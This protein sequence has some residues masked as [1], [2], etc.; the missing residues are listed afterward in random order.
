MLKSELGQVFTKEKEVKKMCSLIKNSGTILEPSAGDGSFYNVL[1]SPMTIGI[2]ID[3][4]VAPKGCLVMDFFDYKTSIKFDTVIGN[5]P[6]LSYNDIPSTTL[7]KLPN[8][9]DKSKGNLYMFFIWKCLDLLSDNGELIFIV[10]RDFIKLTSAAALNNRLNT[11]GGFTYW[12]ELG[13][14]KV[15]DDACPNVVIFRWQKGI[16]HTID[17]HYNNGF[18]SFGKTSGEKISDLFDVKVGAVSGANDIFYNKNGNISL[19]YS[20]TKSTGKFIKAYYGE[21]DVLKPFKDKLLNR[22]GKEFSEKNWWKWVRKPAESKEKKIF[23]NCKTRDDKPFFTTDCECWDSS[24]LALVPKK[25]LNI[26]EY[27]DRLNNTD[28]EKQGFKVGGR[29]IFTQKSLENAIIEN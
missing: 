27:V 17:I 14:Q 16:K 3:K 5:P 29:L 10:P 20:K 18:F 12:E 19:A 2:E 24:L 25:D 21:L 6:Y 22:K 8:I 28:W 15:F 11:E 23:V 7:R 9:M 4:D 1:P 13:D 26:N